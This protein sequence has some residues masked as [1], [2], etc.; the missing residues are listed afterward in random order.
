MAMLRALFPNAVFKPNQS[1]VHALVTFHSRTLHSQVSALIDSGATESFI[2]PD[3]VQHFDIPTHTLRKPRI[4]RN[5]D[6]TKNSIG[7]ITT[8]ATL[9][10]HYQNKIT[11]HTFYIIDLGE[12]HMLLGMPFLAATNPYIDWSKGAFRGKVTATTIDAYKWTPRQDSKV[13]KPFVKPPVGYRHFER[14]NEPTQYL[15]VTPEDYTY[16]RRAQ[17]TKYPLSALKKSAHTMKR[18]TIKSIAKPTHALLRKLTKATALAA[19]KAD[20][21]QRHWRE[22]IPLEYHKFGKVFSNTAAERF[23]GKHP[24]DHAIDLVEDTPGTLDCKTYPLG[25]GQQKLLDEFIAEHLKKGYIRTSSSPYA[26]PFFFVKKKD[27]K[28]RPVQ[29]YRKLNGITVRNTYPLPLIKELIRQLVGKEWFTKFDIRWRYNNVRIKEGDQWKAAFKTNRG[30]FEPTVMF[31]GLTNSP[32]TFQTMMDAIFREEVASGDVII[33]MDDILIATN[34]SLDH[35]RTKVTHVLKKL[36]DNDLFLKPE[37]CHFH[38]KEVEYLGVIV[39]K[40]Q[41]KMDP[42]KVQGITDWPR[43]EERRVGKECR[44]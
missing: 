14:T 32:A 12:D 10:I 9:D 37:K 42:V 28:Q 2:S 11:T 36:L 13:Y 20:Q 41:V 6:G 33:Y 17:W 35:H 19:E 4:I 43:S 38:K 15:N 5:V 40:G 25:E 18:K 39:G 24:W 22:L 31:F 21:T 26:S 44:L 29:D 3:L 16:L 30:L 7:D 34:G 23:P 1:S 27:G 8:A